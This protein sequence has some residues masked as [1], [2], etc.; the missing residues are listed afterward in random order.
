MVDCDV[1]I[2]GGGPV[3]LFLAQFCIQLGA[4][5]VIAIEPNPYRRQLAASIG[6]TV[7]EPGPNALEYINTQY[8]FRTGVDYGFEVS[9]APS[10]LGALLD[11][12]R[13]EGTV[14][15]IGH[16]SA[17]IEISRC[18]TIA[19]QPIST[20]TTTRE[21]VNAASP[22]ASTMSTPVTRTM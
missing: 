15:T 11:G 12:V 21:L 1:V 3:G 7:F 4:R 22:T 19:F 18:E 14:V 16:P 9:A 5:E 20:P 13:R 2:V 10:A 8:E 6:T 17:P